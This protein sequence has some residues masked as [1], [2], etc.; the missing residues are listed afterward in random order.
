M[1]RKIHGSGYLVGLWHLNL[2]QVGS[3][4]EFTSLPLVPGKTRSRAEPLPSNFTRAGGQGEGEIG[5][6]LVV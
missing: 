4:R 1:S 6:D 3:I 5:F 2:S